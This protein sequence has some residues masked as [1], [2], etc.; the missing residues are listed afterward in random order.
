MN[1]ARVLSLSV[2]S[3]TVAA[4]TAAAP[5]SAGVRTIRAADSSVSDSF[6]TLSS[7]NRRTVFRVTSG[8][9]DY[10]VDAEGDDRPEWRGQIFDDPK[11]PT[12]YG[13]SWHEFR[14]NDVS[15]S[16]TCEGSVY[17]GEFRRGQTIA[18]FEFKSGFD[19]P[20]VGLIQ[21]LDLWVE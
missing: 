7:E 2:L 19:C 14:S 18:T 8:G 5:V 21:E 12:I 1:F 13:N 15:S 11:R 16:R 4:F 6:S 10:F 3:V 17:F 20:F 9:L